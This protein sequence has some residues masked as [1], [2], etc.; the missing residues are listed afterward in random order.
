[1][2]LGMK[3]FVILLTLNLFIACNPEDDM[4]E[5]PQYETQSGLDT[6]EEETL[7]DNKKNG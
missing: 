7:I 1:M 3:L 6:N 5:G 2:K 4:E